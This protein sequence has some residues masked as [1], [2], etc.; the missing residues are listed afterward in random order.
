MGDDPH[1]S[2]EQEPVVSCFPLGHD[3]A[4]SDIAL[5]FVAP[6]GTME[7]EV[8]GRLMKGQPG[9]AEGPVDE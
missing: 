2:I 3:T 4:R 1:A 8:V 7:S 5:A 6:I 9:R